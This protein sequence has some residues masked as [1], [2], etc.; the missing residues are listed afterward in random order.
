[1]SA[2]PV[3]EERVSEVYREVGVLRLVLPCEAEFDGLELGRGG[4][5]RE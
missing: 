4:Y 5:D 3:V 2:L 1:M